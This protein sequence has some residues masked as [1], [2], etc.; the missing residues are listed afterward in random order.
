MASMESALAAFV[1]ADRS[2]VICELW[3]KLRFTSHSGF[4]N[5][6]SGAAWDSNAVGAAVA[7][8]DTAFA[9]LGSGWTAPGRTGG[10]LQKP[11]CHSLLPSWLQD[12]QHAGRVAWTSNCQTIIW[13]RETCTGKMNYSNDVL[14]T[15]CSVCVCMDP[16]HTDV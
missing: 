14:H 8:G 4:D 13:S 11:R 15:Q 12:K 7:K 6:G 2:A 5:T 9:W 1:L 16:D 3:S 10:E